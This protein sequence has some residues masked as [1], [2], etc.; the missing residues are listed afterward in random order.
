M[1]DAFLDDLCA[2]YDVDVVALLAA[3]RIEGSTALVV[4]QTSPSRRRCPHHL[5][6]AIGRATVAFEPHESLVGIGTLVKLVDAFARRLTLQEMIGEEV[7]NAIM[8]HLKPKWAGCRLM[9]EHAC[10]TARGEHRHG[11]RIESVALKGALDEAGRCHAHR[12]L[13]VGLT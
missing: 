1:A 4:A 9:M 7:T 5:L 12:S 13:G 8:V 3:N 11:V 10:V 2:G 6:P